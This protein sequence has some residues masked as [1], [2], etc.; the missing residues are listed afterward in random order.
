M[1]KYGRLKWLL[2]GATVLLILVVAIG[3]YARNAWQERSVSTTNLTGAEVRGLS[4][5][6]PAD[7]LDASGLQP[8]PDYENRTERGK[9]YRYYDGLMLV[10]DESTGK[11]TKIQLISETVKASINGKPLKTLEDADRELGNEYVKKPYNHEQGLDARVYYD[12]ENR[13]RATLVY[14]KQDAENRG[15]VWTILERY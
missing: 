11:V 13:I 6:G 2:F 9:T 5:G 1:R 12:K 7:R 10:S 4:I 15:I 3:G 8:N 14:P